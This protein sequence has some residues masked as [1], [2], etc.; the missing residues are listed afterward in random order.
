[1]K[2]RSKQFKPSLQRI[3]VLMSFSFS[4]LGCAEP[5]TYKKIDSDKAKY[6][7]ISAI[8]DVGADCGPKDSA[9]IKRALYHPLGPTGSWYGSKPNV[10]YTQQK[11]LNSNTFF[12][13][14]GLISGY[15][16]VTEPGYLQ[17]RSYD[18]IYG[19]VYCGWSP[20]RLEIAPT[21]KYVKVNLNLCTV[22]DGGLAQIHELAFFPKSSGR[23]ILIF[24]SAH[25]QTEKIK[26][27]DFYEPS[28]LGNSVQ[29]KRD[30]AY[31]LVFNHLAEGDLAAAKSV[32]NDA[33]KILAG[34]QDSVTSKD[35]KL[36][37]IP[38]R[39][40]HLEDWAMIESL[41]AGM[42]LAEPDFDSKS[43][44]LT[45]TV[46]SDI[47]N[48]QSFKT[49]R[50]CIRKM[51]PIFKWLGDQVK[52]G[53]KPGQQFQ[54]I[55][56]SN[57]EKSFS[58]H[59]PRVIASYLNGDLSEKDYLSHGSFSYSF[60]AGVKA[61]MNHDKKKAYQCF[62]DFLADTPYE[63][64]AFESA[65]AAKLQHLTDVKASNLPSK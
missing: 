16:K 11:E 1:M 34:M 35:G 52:S 17:A 5:D 48:D 65:A 40:S 3:L 12:M 4:A 51:L 62:H 42:L 55:D 39:E 23:G 26:L 49:N 24:T 15:V 19:D 50:E 60:W 31:K 38:A 2:Q 29:F 18:D 14:D 44:A 28:I 57:L 56:T 22:G 45:A 13:H 30:I 7:S 20:D 9:S 25:P 59:D 10:D 33:K 63:S 47:S 21:K 6:P 64:L 27:S 32:L 41:E 36:V 8:R 46:N 53:I 43:L 37:P 54:K 58:A 61:L